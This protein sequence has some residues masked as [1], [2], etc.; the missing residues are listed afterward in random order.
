MGFDLLN[1]V[2]IILLL[3]VA[4]LL[5]GPKKLPEIGAGLGRSIREFRQAMVGI[6]S[7]NLASTKDGEDVDQSPRDTV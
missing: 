3:I 4:L 1:P 5:F 6:V 2:H 7:E